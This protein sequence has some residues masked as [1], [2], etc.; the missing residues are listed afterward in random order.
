[1][2]HRG[3]RLQN[4]KKTQLQQI[5]KPKCTKTQTTERKLGSSVNWQVALKQQGVKQSIISNII[6]HHELRLFRPV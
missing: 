1:M 5:N 6:I 4:N 2:C 3:V